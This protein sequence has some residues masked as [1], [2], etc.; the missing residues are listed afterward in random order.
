[1]ARRSK[2]TP[3]TIAKIEQGISLGMTYKLAAQYAGIGES[4]FYQ[5]VKEAEE[6]DPRKQEFAEALNRAEARGA[7]AA[8]A[9]I[10]Q[11]AKGGTWQAAAWILERRYAYKRESIMKHAD[12]RAADQQKAATVDPS[13]DEGRAAIIEQISELPED[14]ILA[15]L[16]RRSAAEV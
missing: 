12:E 9:C 1:M 14:L 2:C 8:L 16:N 11:A 4:T 13:T 3:E 7:A 15:A 10:A 6:G 5:W